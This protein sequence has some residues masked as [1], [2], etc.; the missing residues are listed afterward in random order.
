M[1]QILDMVCNQNQNYLDAHLP[2][3][4]HAYNNAVGVATGL[5]PTEV[6]LR[7]LLCLTLTD[8]DR[9]Y[10]DTHQSLDRDQL[11]YCDL[12]REHQQCTDKLVR[13]QHAVSVARI[14]SRSWSHSDALFLRRYL[15]MI[16]E[17]R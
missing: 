5:V 10:R 2:H 17:G 6:H 13:E 4:K 3:V 12:A 1:A 15:K 16:T 7:R 8:F 14:N 9:S 11:D